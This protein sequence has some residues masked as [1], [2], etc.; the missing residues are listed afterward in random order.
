MIPVSCRCDANFTAERSHGTIV[1]LS[2]AARLRVCMSLSAWPLR[3][4]TNPTHHPS[5]ESAIEPSSVP[6][7]SQTQTTSQAAALALLPHSRQCHPA[8]HHRP[9]QQQQKR[10]PHS[11]SHPRQPR[12]PPNTPPPPHYH[13][14]PPPLARRRAARG[15]RRR[16]RARLYALSLSWAAEG[17]S[18]LRAGACRASN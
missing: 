18:T 5:R 6:W 3:P 2:H 17:A 16:R 8:P 12:C 7:P 9:P 13:R 14:R 11:P 1:S 4:R 15:Q 10:L